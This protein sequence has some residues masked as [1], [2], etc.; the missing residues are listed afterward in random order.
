MRL[1]P[2]ASSL[3]AA[4]LRRPVMHWRVLHVPIWM[5]PPVPTLKLKEKT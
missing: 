2:L 4:R 3:Q 1:T 5:H